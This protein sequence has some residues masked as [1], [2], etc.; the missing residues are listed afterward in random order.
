MFVIVYTALNPVPRGVDKKQNPIAVSR[1]WGGKRLG[2]SGTPLRRAARKQ[3]ALRKSGQ[4]SRHST[5]YIAA[6]RSWGKKIR[7]WNRPRGA[8][9]GYRTGPPAIQKGARTGI[10]G[11]PAGERTRRAPTRL[12]Q[13]HAGRMPALPGGSVGSA[14]ET[15][16]GTLDPRARLGQAPRPG[17]SFI[18]TLQMSFPQPATPPAQRR[19]KIFT[20]WGTQFALGRRERPSGRAAKAFPSRAT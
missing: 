15:V 20:P 5:P 16:S 14:P 19:P 17:A 10:A 3:H 18:Q 13:H 9:H 6:P 8:T 7:T 11:L 4:Q 2:R 12:R 1:R